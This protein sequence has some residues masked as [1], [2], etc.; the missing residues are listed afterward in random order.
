MK[1]R[2][3]QWF[4]PDIQARLDATERARVVY[5]CS[6]YS[7]DTRRNTHLASCY[8]RHALEEGYTPIASHL[9]L[10]QFM[11]E[12]TE[13]EKALTQA[14]ILLSL[15]DEIWIFGHLTE[16]MVAEW[17]AALALGI[18][19]RTFATFNTVAPDGHEIVGIQETTPPA[20]GFVPC[21]G[22]E[23]CQGGEAK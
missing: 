14:T 6:P 1:T 13:R 23:E 9:L 7:G 8:A 19:V 21:E 2:K 11:D 22:C 3:P 17:K 5:I 10:P 15:C 4:E 12:E 20:N 18:E 16:G